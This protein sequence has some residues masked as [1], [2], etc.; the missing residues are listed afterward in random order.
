VCRS[1]G[2]E[3]VIWQAITNTRKLVYCSLDHFLRNSGLSYLMLD[4]ACSIFSS[5]LRF[6]LCAYMDAIG[7]HSASHP[8]ILQYLSLV[9]S[10]EHQS[11]ANNAYQH[12]FCP[13]SHLLLSIKS[14]KLPSGVEYTE[15][16]LESRLTAQ[17]N[18][19][20]DIC[21]VYNRARLLMNVIM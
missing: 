21:M 8:L 7:V 10:F 2:V 19:V 13:N 18:H 15:G 12:V 4:M 9:V 20:N 6:P 14:F 1:P 16:R 17:Y 3:L 5:S 11:R